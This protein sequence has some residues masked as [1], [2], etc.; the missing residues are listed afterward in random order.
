MST[1]QTLLV[2]LEIKAEPQ[3]VRTAAAL[4]TALDATVILLHVIEELDAPA[5]ELT[6][7]YEKLETRASEFLEEAAAPLRE[8]GVGHRTKVVF[9]KR[10]AEI[11]AFSDEHDVDLVVLRSHR[12]DPAN[13][14]R[15]F[16]T[17]SHQVAIAGGTSVLLVR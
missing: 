1:F 8:A 14:A 4:A 10:A 11:V 17:I 16:M 12:M 2:P 15:Q 3:T 6:S 9:G 7:F 13:P 5:K